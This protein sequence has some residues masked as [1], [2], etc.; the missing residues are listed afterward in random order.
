MKQITALRNRTNHAGTYM[1]HH[2]RAEIAYAFLPQLKL[3]LCLYDGR[4]EH[5]LAKFSEM[6]V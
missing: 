5:A 2:I 1:N 4:R 6:N 3:L